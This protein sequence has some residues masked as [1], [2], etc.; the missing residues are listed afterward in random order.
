M[1]PI[2]RCAG[3]ARSAA[4]QAVHLRDWT[5][6]GLLTGYSEIPEKYGRILRGVIA[7]ENLTRFDRVRLSDTR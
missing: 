6:P 2:Q 3:R 5:W 1:K 7:A 4:A